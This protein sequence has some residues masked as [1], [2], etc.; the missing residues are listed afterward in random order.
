M[1]L[2]NLTQKAIQY[3]PMQLRHPN[4]GKHLE[5]FLSLTVIAWTYLSATAQS[6]DTL[7]YRHSLQFNLAGPGFGL[8]SGYSF[9]GPK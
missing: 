7:F 9:G 8:T 4:E 6:N 2:G 3:H 1:N 5:K